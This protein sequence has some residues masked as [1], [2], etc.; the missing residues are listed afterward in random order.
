MAQIQFSLHHIGQSTYTLEG[1]EQT[2]VRFSDSGRIARLEQAA[3]EALGAFDLLRW[4]VPFALAPQGHVVL[5]A[6]AVLRDQNCYAFLGISEVGKSTL[7]EELAERGWR[8]VADDFLLCSGA[9][10]VNAVGEEQLRA[11]CGEV[12]DRAPRPE[13]IPYSDLARRL[14]SP[15]SQE[16]VRLT[17]LFF[18][19]EQRNPGTEFSFTPVSSPAAF[20]RLV[21]VGFGGLP[22]PRAWKHQFDAYTSLA[23]RVPAGVLR[24]PE[25]LEPMRRSLSGL[26]TSLGQWIP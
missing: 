5:H 16:W 12:A 17:G 19:D 3:E 20:T 10:L 15:D 23:A 9:G 21:D 14:E 4:G 11:W 22:T 25:G 24:A 1:G 8:Q 7:A 26:E 2:L 13:A 18:L 6:S